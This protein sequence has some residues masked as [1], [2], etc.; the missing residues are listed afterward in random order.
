MKL[1]VR[2]GHG[3]T[4]IDAKLNIQELQVLA[5][6]RDDL[7][8][9]VDAIA[10]SEHTKVNTADM[11][12][13]I[14]KTIA[15]LSNIVQDIQGFDKTAKE[16]FTFEEHEVGQNVTEKEYRTELDNFDRCK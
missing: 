7:S 4:G 12:K 15:F 10:D 5:D 8:Q 1:N 16:L 9:V 13:V 2:T 3:F 14:N 6:H 11:A